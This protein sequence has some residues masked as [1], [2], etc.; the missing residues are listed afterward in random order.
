MKVVVSSAAEAELGAILHIGK[1]AVWL[2]TSL[3]DMGHAQ[4]PTPIQTDNSCAAGIAKGTLNQRRSNAIDMRFYWIRDRVP[5][6]QFI[7]HWRQ[8][9]DNLANYFTKHHSPSRHRLMRS[10]YLL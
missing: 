10:R 6:G 3:N 1:K 4:P 2:R 7:M 9:S 5:Q 8:G